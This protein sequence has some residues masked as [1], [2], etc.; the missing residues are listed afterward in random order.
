MKTK[1]LILFIGIF[2]LTSFNFASAQED[3]VATLKAR[4]EALQE[5]IAKMQEEQD[6]E[7]LI[8]KDSC[9]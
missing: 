1:L 9:T 7:V 5:Q 2:L 3:L 4:I 6:E 8:Q